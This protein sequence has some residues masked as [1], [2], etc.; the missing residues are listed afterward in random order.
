MSPNFNAYFRWIIFNAPDHV[1]A[2][3]REQGRPGPAYLTGFLEGQPLVEEDES[4]HEEAT[5]TLDDGVTP[6]AERLPPVSH[7]FEVVNRT[8]RAIDILSIDFLSRDAAPVRAEIGSSVGADRF[9]D[10]EVLFARLRVTGC[11]VN[12]RLRGEERSVTVD[13]QILSSEW[14]LYGT[15]SIQEFA[16]GG[17]GDYQGRIGD[18]SSSRL[19]RSSLPPP[20]RALIELDPAPEFPDPNCGSP[21]RLRNAEAYPIVVRLSATYS[22]EGPTQYCP[23]GEVAT[24]LEPRHLGPGEI[25]RLGCTT[26]RSPA[27]WCTERR[28]WRVLS[29]TRAR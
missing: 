14:S 1:W 9:V 2:F 22:V 11:Q 6:P 4:H 24:P 20:P 12:Y 28:S 17:L 16:D 18:D 8:G 3:G 10:V 5:T 26:Y 23:P 25:W 19:P 21:M 15:V 7:F 13:F 27:M 29:A